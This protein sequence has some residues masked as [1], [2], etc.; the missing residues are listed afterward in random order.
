MV[1]EIPYE[2][3]PLTR[4][5]GFFDSLNTTICQISVIVCRLFALILMYLLFQFPVMGLYNSDIVEEKFYTIWSGLVREERFA[6]VQVTT[7]G[8][9]TVLLLNIEHPYCIAN[10]LEPFMKMEGE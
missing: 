7:S 10:Y 5:N 9:R 2:I 1:H 4:R 8:K 3:M 6:P